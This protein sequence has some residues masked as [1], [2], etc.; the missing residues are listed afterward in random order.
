MSEATRPEWASGPEWEGWSVDKA[1]GEAV[2]RGLRNPHNDPHDCISIELRRNPIIRFGRG[3]RW[4]AI[5][6]YGGT[7]EGALAI[8]NAYAEDAGGW[9]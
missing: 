7:V 4:D 6:L 9:A 2:F 5:E 8:G 3:S 1:Y